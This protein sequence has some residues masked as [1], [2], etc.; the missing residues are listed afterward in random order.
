MSIS[1]FARTAHAHRSA[2]VSGA[3]VP[4][5]LDVFPSLSVTLSSL[6]GLGYNRPNPEIALTPP[7]AFET[8]LCNSQISSHRTRMPAFDE[9]PERPEHIDQILNGLDRYN[10]QTTTVFQEYVT[11]QCDTQSYDCY[12][13]I[14]LLK[15][16]VLCGFL[17]VVDESL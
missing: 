3:W 11:Q 15:L 14:A 17:F 9:A 8:H 13:N 10:P 6:I 5:W 7:A 12:A 2:R 4:P 1:P 16:Y